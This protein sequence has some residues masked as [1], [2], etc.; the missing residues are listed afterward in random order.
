MSGYRPF[1]GLVL[2]EARLIPDEGQS[3]AFYGFR[4]DVLRREGN[5]IRSL[6]IA[7]WHAE[8]DGS[9]TDAETTDGDNDL[10][11]TATP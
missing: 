8:G 9:A 2:H 7:P 11:P 3:F 1:A 6:R 5:Q 10:P 4:F